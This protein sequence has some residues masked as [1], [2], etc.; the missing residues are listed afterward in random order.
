MQ[1]KD[2]ECQLI[3]KRLVLLGATVG[4]GV[5]VLTVVP[6]S[7]IERGGILKG[8]VIKTIGRLAVTSPAE[9]RLA[10]DHLI[11]VNEGKQTF[12]ATFGVDRDGQSRVANVAIMPCQKYTK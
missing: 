1:C 4:R 7:A 8:D 11:G 10:I 6:R 5:K 9:C 3:G 12:D 2:P